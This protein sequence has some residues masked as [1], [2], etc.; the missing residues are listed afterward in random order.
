M[1]LTIQLIYGAFMAGLK[2]TAAAPTW[3]SM[4]GDWF[5][6]AIR[7]YGG[8]EFKGISWLTDNPLMIHFIHRN[9]AYL[10]TVLIC[11]WWWKARSVNETNLFNKTK[12]LPLLIVLLQVLL[13]IL[14]VL[15]VLQQNVFLWLAVAHQFTAMLLLL[16]LVWIL[17]IVRGKIEHSGSL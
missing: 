14:T 2:V 7:I 13:G 4:N 5:P 3:P 9:L 8:H 1:L 11:V 16:S 10:I 6:S 17:F 15:N 12:M